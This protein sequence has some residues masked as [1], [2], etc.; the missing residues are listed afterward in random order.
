VSFGLSA[1]VSFGGRGVVAGLAAL[2]VV[3]LAAVDLGVRGAGVAF[4]VGSPAAAF[5]AF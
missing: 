2:L 4:G 5:G 1:S 3:L